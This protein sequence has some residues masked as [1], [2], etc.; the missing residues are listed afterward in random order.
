MPQRRGKSD[1]QQRET[2]SRGA[3]VKR[4]SA[5]KGNPASDRTIEQKLEATKKY[6]TMDFR[7]YFGVPALKK[8]KKASEEPDQIPDR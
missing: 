3:S 1:E 7:G 4:K 6:L 8:L 2:S 5:T